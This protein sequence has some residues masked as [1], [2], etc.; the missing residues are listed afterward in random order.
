MHRATWHLMLGSRC[1]QQVS[2]CKCSPGELGAE[3]RREGYHDGVTMHF[4]AKWRTQLQGQ[5]S[6]NYPSRTWN[7]HG[8]ILILFF[9]STQ[10]TRQQQTTPTQTFTK[11]E[12]KT[13]EVQL[14]TIQTK[15]SL[16]LPSLHLQ[17]ISVEALL[18]CLLKISSALVSDPIYS[19]SPICISNHEYCVLGISLAMPFF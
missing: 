18:C 5:L 6:L 12:S 7:A 8:L 9:Y 4:I 16:A 19:L 2:C 10:I 13:H 3:D 15:V 14:L 17:R 1:V 11:K